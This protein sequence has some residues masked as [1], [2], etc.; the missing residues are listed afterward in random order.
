[1]LRFLNIIGM[2]ILMI[3]FFIVGVT[4]IF[5]SG[6]TSMPESF[7]KWLIFTSVKVPLTFLTLLPVF[8]VTYAVCLLSVYPKATSCIGFLCVLFFYYA[9][10]SRPNDLPPSPELI[11]MGIIS[12]E[13]IYSNMY[14]LAWR[15]IVDITFTVGCIVGFFN[16]KG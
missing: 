7:E 1:M 6:I 4:M 5:E 3:L 2:P 9:L 13:S 14:I 16:K 8:G 11:E 12:Q 10:I 15:I